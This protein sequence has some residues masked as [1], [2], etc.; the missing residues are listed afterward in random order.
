MSKTPNSTDWESVLDMIK[1]IQ[2][3]SW[4][5]EFSP[6][7]PLGEL[8]ADICFLIASS[9]EQGAKSLR[10][11]K[12]PKFLDREA[13]N[14]LGNSKV[15][16]IGK[17]QIILSDPETAKFFRMLSHLGMMLRGKRISFAEIRD[18]LTKIIGIK[19]KTFEQHAHPKRVKNSKE[20]L[21]FHKW[22]EKKRH[23]P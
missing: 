19:P 8:F 22:Q 12:E 17:T 11:N 18:F 10:E 16:F 4:S 20:S 23:K 15:I 9:L 5:K 1:K 14:E 21:F 13:P 3:S 2:A 7:E 6:V